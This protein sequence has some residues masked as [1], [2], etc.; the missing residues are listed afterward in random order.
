MRFSSIEVVFHLGRLP[1]RPSSIDVVWFGMVFG[2]F[3]SSFG[4]FPGGDGG[5]GSVKKKIKLI[6]AKP[7]AK[8]SS[9]GLS[10]LGNMSGVRDASLQGGFRGVLTN[11]DYSY[12]NHSVNK[13]HH[14]L[15]EIYQILKSMERPHD[16][17]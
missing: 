11:V 13:E 2:S 15:Q 6:S 14:H 17:L 9:L 16:E 1:L 5:G 7:E 12:F 8:A 3:I 10:E 4:T